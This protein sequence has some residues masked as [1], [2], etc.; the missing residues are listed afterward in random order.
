MAT[1]PTMKQFRAMIAVSQTGS[2]VRAAELLSLSQPAL[3]ETISQLERVVGGRVFQR[4]TRTVVI[5]PF[6]EA[7]LPR[8]RKLLDDI[9]TLCHDMREL[10]DLERGTVSVGCLA[11][12]ASNQLPQIIVAFRKDHPNIRVRV[13]DENAAGLHDRLLAGDIDFA[14][15]S[16]LDSAPGEIQFQPLLVD[17]FRLLCPADHPLAQREEVAWRDVAEH[18][19]LG[20]SEETANHFAIASAL[21]TAAFQ[22]RPHL[23]VAQLGTMLSMVAHGVGVAAVPRLAC[24]NSPAVRAVRLVEPKITRDVGVATHPRRPQTPAAARFTAMTVEWMSS[25]QRVQPQA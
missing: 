6:G 3:S 20:W 5:T 7:L 15:T 4:T 8:A 23:E 12:I 18:L 24:P 1:V 14:I 9:E 25:P 21:A 19:Y 2:F 16:R 13:R 10:A 17:P 11:S 22:L